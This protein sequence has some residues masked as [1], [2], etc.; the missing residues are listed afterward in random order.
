MSREWTHVYNSPNKP[1]E[2][3]GRRTLLSFPSGAVHSREAVAEYM[4]PGELTAVKNDTA[5]RAF[6]EGQAQKHHN[7]RR[8]RQS[9][10][11]KFI[12]EFVWRVG[13][14]SADVKARRLLHEKVDSIF[15][16]IAAVIN[17]ISRVDFVPRRP[18]SRHDA[19]GAASWLPDNLG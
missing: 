16:I 7:L 15:R 1:C 17:K 12:R 18:Q 3:D 10:N 9:V 5:S 14:D 11:H 13:N 19:A 4:D 8:E 2:G 6:K